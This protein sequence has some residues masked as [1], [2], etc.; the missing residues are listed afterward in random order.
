[1]HFVFINPTD[2][3]ASLPT[4]EQQVWSTHDIHMPWA[5]L[6]RVCTASHLRCESWLTHC[7]QVNRPCSPPPVSSSWAN[8]PTFMLSDSK[9]TQILNANICLKVVY[10]VIFSKGDK[11]LPYKRKSFQ[12]CWENWTLTFSTS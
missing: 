1:M 4:E 11:R 9:H 7:V 2:C 10:S 12:H 8:K 5:I 3:H 6:S